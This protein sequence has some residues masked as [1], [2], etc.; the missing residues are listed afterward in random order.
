MP[1]FSV[2]NAHYN[3]GCEIAKLKS[4]PDI[5]HLQQ[6]YAALCYAR[7]EVGDFLV[8]ISSWDVEITDWE[9]EIIC[10]KVSRNKAVQCRI[11]ELLTK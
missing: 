6:Y 1:Y 7:N 11:Y 3:L 2:R 4:R 10:N 5:R 9:A 8:G